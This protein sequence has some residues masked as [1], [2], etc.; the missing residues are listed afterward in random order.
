MAKS[1][2]KP[3]FEAFSNPPKD[4]CVVYHEPTDAKRKYWKTLSMPWVTDEVLRVTGEECPDTG[5]PCFARIHT[6][7]DRI[8]LSPTLFCLP[9]KP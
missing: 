3:P 6:P 7:S 1:K 2:F 4:V 5:Q 8:F 9:G